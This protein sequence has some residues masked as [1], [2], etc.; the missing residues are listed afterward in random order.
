ME[1]EIVKSL[2]SFL[3]AI[4]YQVATWDKK[5]VDH[6]AAHPEKMRDFHSGSP[7][8]KWGIYSSIKYQPN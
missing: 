3:E 5:V 2:A 7:T 1:L 8:T 4:P 6:L